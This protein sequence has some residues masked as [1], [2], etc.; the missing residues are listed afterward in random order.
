MCVIYKERVFENELLGVLIQ[1]LIY[2]YK[3]LMFCRYE[4]SLVLFYL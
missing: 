4:M 3:F 2:Y 1:I